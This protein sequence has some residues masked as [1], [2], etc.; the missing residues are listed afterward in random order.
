[1]DIYDAFFDSYLQDGEFQAPPVVPIQPT[2]LDSGTSSEQYLKPPGPRPPST[3]FKPKKSKATDYDDIITE[4]STTYNVEPELIRAVIGRESNF[5]PNAISPKK[6]TGLMQVL[7]STFKEMGGTDI[8]DPYQNIMHGTKYLA[9]LSK[10]YGGDIPLTLAGYNAG[11]GA[12]DKYGGIPPFKETQEYVPNVLGRYNKY[13]KAA[14]VKQPTD[15]QPDV[16]DAFFD[17]YLSQGSEQ[18]GITPEG[19]TP[20]WFKVVKNSIASGLANVNVSLA[21][22]AKDVIQLADAPSRMARKAFGIEQED[23]GVKFLEGYMAS[24]Q[25][26]QAELD[27]SPELSKLPWYIPK[28]IVGTGLQAIPQVALVAGAALMAPEAIAAKAAATALGTIAY[29]SSAEEAKAEGASEVQQILHGITAAEIEVI[30][31]MPV[32]GAIGKLWK[33]LKVGGVVEKAGVNFITKLLK[34]FGLFGK[35]MAFET[36]QEM[37]AYLGGQ[38]SKRLHYDPD[39]PITMEAL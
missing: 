25:K 37:E 29:G 27:I 7:P 6:A 2:W 8:T 4:A 35:G 23:P 33:Y 26:Q 28:R 5:N 36:V 14:S 39:A 11:P 17:S 31:E 13:K 34:G 1:M 19:Q 32:F 38:M 16:L 22:G 18:G 9:Q 12:V 21:R 10:K 30:T 15:S 24:Q 3:S 20:S